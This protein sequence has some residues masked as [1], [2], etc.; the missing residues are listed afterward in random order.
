M[1]YGLILIAV[2]LFGGSFAFNDQYRR[3][4]GDSLKISLQFSLISAT[5]G[6]IILLVV[7][8]F[9]LECTPFTLL[10]AL[11][12]ALNGFGFT[13]CAFKALGRINLSLYS[14]FSMLGGMVL[15]FL[16]GILFY[17]ERFTLTKG[18]C[19][20]FIVL[21][22]LLTIKR[23]E[24]KGG[25]IYYIGI[26]LLN[27]MSGVLS[28]LFTELPFEKATAESYSIWGALWTVAL[29][30]LL[31]PLFRKKEPTKETFASLG[32]GALAGAANRIANLLLV[33]A[34]AKVETSVQ[35]PMV[36]GGVMIVSTLIC[37]FGQNKPSKQELLSVV[38]AFFGMLILFIL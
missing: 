37:F 15:P 24:G 14:V 13:F 6:V 11:L 7:N 27:G 8:R 34:L 19:L 4:R 17:N 5:A 31:L 23:G 25:T 12:S 9:E 36:T 30:A 22:L 2:L 20:A 26:F 33:V 3:L 35:Y 10:M 28:K 32:F 29:A 38:F 21:A 16:L 18:L 1:Y